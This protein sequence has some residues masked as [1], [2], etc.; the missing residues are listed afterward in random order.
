MPSLKNEHERR[1]ESLNIIYQIKQQ[2]LNSKH[3]AIKHLL[4]LLTAYV[5]TGIG[6]NINIPY[7]EI[8]KTILGELNGEKN[9][10]CSVYLRDS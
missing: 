7:P 4:E 9:K 1:N 10:E 8:N 3:S 6:C 5:L 2:N